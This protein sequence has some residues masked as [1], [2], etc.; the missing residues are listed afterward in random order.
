MRFFCFFR[1]LCVVNYLKKHRIAVFTSVS[2]IFTSIHL[3]IL[4]SSRSSTVSLACPHVRFFAQSY[5]RLVMGPS[6]CAYRPAACWCTRTFSIISVLWYLLFKL[7][8]KYAHT[9]YS[10]SIHCFRFGILSPPVHMSLST[11]F[12][13]PF[14]LLCRAE[15]NAYGIITYTFSFIASFFAR[16]R[17]K[18]IKN[19]LFCLVTPTLFIASEIKLGIFCICVRLSCNF[20]VWH[21]L[22]HYA[23]TLQFRI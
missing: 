16:R 9:Q 13:I 8:T 21:A 22:N 11:R 14:P 19:L 20:S 6:D 17:V 10:E 12:V 5:T 2:V 18:F 3:F 15:R 7:W 23:F 1:L 4:V